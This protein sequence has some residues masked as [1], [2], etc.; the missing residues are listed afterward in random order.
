[1]SRAHALVDELRMRVAARVPAE[2]AAQCAALAVRGGLGP[3]PP[4]ALVDDPLPLP[5]PPRPAGRAR[6]RTA[7]PTAAS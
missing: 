3:P 6:T 5:D 4:G 7:R 2:L 1:M